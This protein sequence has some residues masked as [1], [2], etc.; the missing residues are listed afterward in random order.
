MMKHFCTALIVE[1]LS[2]IIGT[3][4]IKRKPA[5]RARDSQL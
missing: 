5:L 2:S 4:H 3:E 1:I